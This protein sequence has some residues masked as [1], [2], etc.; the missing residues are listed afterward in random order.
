MTE[1]ENALLE[2]ILEKKKL[3]LYSDLDSQCLC[4]KLPSFN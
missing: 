4:K 3:Y 2:N 1:V